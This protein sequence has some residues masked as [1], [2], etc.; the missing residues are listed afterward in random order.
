MK[1]V[2]FG[3]TGPQLTRDERA[4]FAE[5]QPLGFILF[6]RNIE[7]PPQV[8]A[9]TQALRDVVGRTHVPILIDQEG[10]RVAR[11]GPPHWPTFPAGERFDALYKRAPMSAIEAARVNAEAMGLML[12]DLGITANCAPVLDLSHPETHGAIGDRSLGSDPLQVAALGRAIL[13]GLRAGGVVGVVKHMPGQGRATHDS[14][15]DLPEVDADVDALS[16]DLR[17][18]QALNGAA[19]GMTGHVLFEAWDQHHCATLSAMVIQEVIRGTIGFD[20]LL[21]SDDLTMRALQGP[22]ADR[23]AACLAAGCDVALHCSADLAEMDA[24]A[25]RLPDISTASRA[26]LDRAM[27]LVSPGKAVDKM[28]ALMDKRDALLAYAT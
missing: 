3:L 6:G 24:I 16:A 1:P 11:L 5:A 10:G 22:L 9:L 13:D 4:L 12:S 8:R 7:S 23:A 20:G 18:F 27:A 15:V 17:P 14:H 28:A 2:I 19:I 26:R 25:A 21:L